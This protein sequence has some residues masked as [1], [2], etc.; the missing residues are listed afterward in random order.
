MAIIYDFDWYSAQNLKIQTKT[1][2]IQPFQLRKVQKRYLQHLKDDFKDG[3]VRSICLK[4]RQA[5]WSTL[6]AGINVHRMCTEY[7]YRGIV[8]ADKFARTQ[9]I[10]GIYT[11]MI[12]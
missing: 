4:P 6:M 12:D 11:T 10:H 5:G 9:A 2:G 3:I 1:S 8:A 7:S